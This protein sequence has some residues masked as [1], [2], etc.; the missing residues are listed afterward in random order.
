MPRLFAD[1][2]PPP[3][4]RDRRTVTKTVTS[5]DSSGIPT[6]HSHKYTLF[7]TQAD[8]GRII[9]ALPFSHPRQIIDILPIL[10]QWA[11]LG[12]LLRRS[13][14]PPEPPS[15]S[16]TKS[17]ANGQSEEDDELDLDDVQLDETM[18][19]E[20]ELAALLASPSSS[21]AADKLTDGSFAA[22]TALPID[23]SLSTSPSLPRI[24]VVWPHGERLKHVEFRVGL[25]GAID[26]HDGND[27]SDKEMEESQKTKKI[28]EIAEDVG[29]LVEWYRRDP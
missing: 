22:E 4:P 9:D 21:P 19:V 13:F 28:L 11:L 6:E 10:R 24:G 15:D 7:P 18:T 23:I 3:N 29:V 20:E 26:V 16:F 25:N 5:Y 2:A 27:S 1:T 17:T 14:V 8:Y 12:S